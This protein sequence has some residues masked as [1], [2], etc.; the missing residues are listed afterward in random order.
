MATRW[1]QVGRGLAD[2]V[3]PPV[4]VHCRGLVEDSPLRQVCAT[5]AEQITVITDPRCMTC[6][7]PFF[8]ELEGERMCPHCADLAPAF[9]EGRAVVLLKGPA[10]ALVHEFK[11]HHGLHVL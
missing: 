10:R 2:V 6:G 8:G 11:Y 4:C 1:Q 7:H 5:C 9:R 3:F